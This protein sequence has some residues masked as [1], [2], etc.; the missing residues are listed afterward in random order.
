M[1]R[2]RHALVLALV[3]VAAFVAAGVASAAVKTD[4][5]TLRDAVTVEGIMDHEE[6]F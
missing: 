1:H 3:L 4:S 2:T 5:S 6:K